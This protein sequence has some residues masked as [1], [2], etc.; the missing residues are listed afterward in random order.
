MANAY[1]TRRD[2]SF[3]QIKHFPIRLDEFVIITPVINSPRYIARAQNYFKFRDVCAAGGVRLVTAEIAL[4]ERPFEV[5]QSDDIND[6]QFRTIDELWHKENAINRAIAHVRREVP[7]VKYIGWFDS[8]QFPISI[9]PRHWFEEIV[10][11]LQHYK[12]VQC[13]EYLLNFGPDG[14]PITG[15]QMS[16]MKTYAAAG[17]QI[18]KGKNVKHTLAGNSGMVSLGRPG[19]AWAANVSALDEIGGGAGPLLDKC[20]I[21]SGDWHMAHALVGGISEQGGYSWEADRLTNYCKYLLEFQEKCERWIKRDVGF[22]PVTVGHWYH[23]SKVTR[24]YGDRGRILVENLYDPHTDVKYDS[25][26]ILQLETWEPRQIRLRDLIRDYMG[27]R[28][29]DS[30]PLR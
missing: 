23:G 5:T 20:I 26:G 28:N 7:N 16:F 19:L 29:E 3:S 21:G 25:Q 9:T 18:P 11:Q 13:W 30:V 22:V 27:S 14:Q 2:G 12:I 1:V 17:Y 6:L 24:K 15:P 8:D 10:H 4:G